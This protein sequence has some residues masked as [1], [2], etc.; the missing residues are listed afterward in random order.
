MKVFEVIKYEG[1]N[2]IFVWKFPGEDFNTLSQLIVSESQEAVFF[3]NGRALDLFGPGKYTLHTQNIPL[4]RR[5]INLPFN[6]VS[7]FH[8]SVYFFNKVVSMNVKWGTAEP[9]QIQD[10]KYSTVI[11]PVRAYGQFAVKVVDSKKL[12]LSLVGTINQ[13][14]HNTLK[15]YFKGVL[16][17]NIKDFIAS[18]LIKNSVSFLEIHT[19][20]KEI[21][22]GIEQDLAAEFEQYGIEL[23]N[24][25]V[26]NI[27]VPENDP[28]FI[29]LKN[30]LNKKTEMDILGYSYQ[31]ERTFDVL[32][33]AA[34]NQGMSSGFM[35]AGMGLGMGLNVG[36][37]VGSAMGSALNTIQTKVEEPQKEPEKPPKTNTVKCQ[38]CGNELPEGAKFCLEC[39]S[40]IEPPI[41]EGM[42]KCPKCESIVPAG[43]F[44]LECGA[45]LKETCGNC[46]AE[47]IPNAKFCL[48]CGNKFGE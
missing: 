9:M 30:I 3:N 4:I 35:N 24:F 19:K 2:D 32:D 42:L 7:P 33:S 39:G 36:G 15:T 17:T 14:D 1:P 47:K 23:V 37:A 16:M 27:D 38:K 34:S 8:C 45:L 18:E 41:K 6:G 12:L 22:S 31:Q 21:S 40:K 5:L 25:Y 28:S 11:L 29:R 10:A 48:E 26:T 13:F 43:K 44:C 20:L 46:G